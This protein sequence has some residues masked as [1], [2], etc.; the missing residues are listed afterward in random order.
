M[1]LECR[2]RV[3]SIR[4]RI[5]TLLFGGPNRIIVGDERA[6]VSEK[7]HLNASTIS[8]ARALKLLDKLHPLDQ[9]ALNSLSLDTEALSKILPDGMSDLE[10]AT[11]LRWAA[12]SLER[13]HA[14][15]D[16]KQRRRVILLLGV[17]AFTTSLVAIAAL[18]SG[19]N[20]SSRFGRRST[21]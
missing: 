8:G 20:R 6:S 19:S 12:D 2:C 1:R 16:Q 17:T 5:T 3:S 7:T 13:A 14:D 18:S 11:L 9:V 21:R 10:G 4:R 15:R